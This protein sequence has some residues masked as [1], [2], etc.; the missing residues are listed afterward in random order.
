MGEL[1]LLMQRLA[2]WISNG[3]RQTVDNTVKT[4]AQNYKNQ[5]RAGLEADGSQMAPLK[6]AT[7]RS[8]IRRGLSQAESISTIRSNLGKTPLNA[9][10]E[11]ANSITAKKVAPDTWEI[12]PNS[13]HGQKI[14][15]SNAKTSHHGFPFMGDTPKAVRDPLQVSDKQMDLLEDR[16]VADLEKILR[17]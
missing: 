4:M 10:G 6:P 12:S 16:I 1:V 17:I 8:P 5:I 14:L 9:T 2:T 15:N 11:T 7:L 3:S 13:K